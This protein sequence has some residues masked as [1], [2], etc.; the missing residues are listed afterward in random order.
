MLKVNAMFLIY[1]VSQKNVPPLA[2]YNFDTCERILIFF[3][4]NVTDKVSNQTTLYYAT[5][6]NLCFC[7]TWQN[8]KHKNCIF[9]S[10]AVLVHCLNSTSCCLI[11]S[12]ILLKTHIQAPV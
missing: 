10:H 12:I 2:C 8:G 7:T 3:G 6:N 11:Y 5:S 9:D 1:T 4:R